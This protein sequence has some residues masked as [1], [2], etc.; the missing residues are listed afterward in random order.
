MFLQ[1]THSTVNS[2]LSISRALAR[3]SP[4]VSSSTLLNKATVDN[5]K[6]TVRTILR[7]EYRAHSDKQVH[8]L[9]PFYY[10]L[11]SGWLFPVFSVSTGSKP[12]VW[13]LP[14]VPRSPWATNT[15]AIRLWTGTWLM[16]MEKMHRING[17]N[18]FICNK[19]L[20]FYIMSLFGC[21]KTCRRS[22]FFKLK[23]FV[24]KMLVQF[25]NFLCP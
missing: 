13:L 16:N 18:T 14:L 8:S 19:P 23:C 17:K 15:E 22:L 12:T 10:R 7:P 20:T 24:D 1:V 4:S 5:H 9:Y 21:N 11:W 2:K 3:S 25:I 6:D